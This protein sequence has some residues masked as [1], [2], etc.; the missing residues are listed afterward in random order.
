MTVIVSALSALL[1]ALGGS[2]LLYFR[3]NRKLKEIEVEAKQ[4]EEWKKLYETSDTDSREKDHKI[5]A[6]YSE[7]QGLLERLI[8]KERVIASKDIEMERLSFARCDVNECRKRKPPRRYEYNEQFAINNEQ[9]NEETTMHFQK[10]SQ[11][12]VGTPAVPPACDGILQNHPGT[13]ADD[14]EKGN[15][16]GNR[17]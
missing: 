7:R 5:D 15:C 17:A 6:L 14:P 4:S 3:Q 10:P 1:G 2:G 9:R 13:A 16:D 8:E 12:V 11:G